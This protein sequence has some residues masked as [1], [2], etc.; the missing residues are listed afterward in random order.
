S[1]PERTAAVAPVQNKLRPFLVNP[2]LRAV[3][4]QAHPRFEVSGLF[5][6]RTILLVNLAKGQIGPEAA[7]LLGSLLIAQ[8]W[9]ASLGRSAIPATRRKAVFLYIDEFQDYL[10]LPVDLAEALGQARALGV[11]LVMA[12]QHLSQL[13]P[14]MRSA[15]LANARSRMCFQLALE[16]AQVMARDHEIEPADFMDLPAFECYLRLVAGDAVQ[17]WCSGRSLPAPPVTGNADRVRAQ[18]RQRYGAP[19]AEVDAAITELVGSGRRRPDED[20]LAPK[21]RG[22][23]SS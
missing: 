10:N 20:D 8:L 2:R 12:H 11:G 23:G 13:D 1:E 3:L 22:G 5:T 16:D 21:R 17:P 15:V 6:G 18:S 4:G 9:Q 7:N 19:R 14:G